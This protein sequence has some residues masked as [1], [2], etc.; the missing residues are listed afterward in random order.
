MT[1]YF[2][3]STRSLLSVFGLFLALFIVSCEDDHDHDEEHT[4]AEGFI[5]ETS[6]GTEMYREFKGTQTGSVTLS[7]GD[8]LELSVHFLDDNGKE[9]EHDE[10]EGGEEEEEGELEVSGFNSIV[11]LVQVE[12]EH[13]D[14]GD[15]EEHEMGLEIIGVSIGSTSFKLELM[16]DGHADYT[17]TN[18]IPIVVK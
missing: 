12:E 9:M 3:K 4:D 14:H 13:D 16:H 6:S 1:I 18:N 5:L 17:S 7:A 15:E 10:H 8:T 11:A 2:E